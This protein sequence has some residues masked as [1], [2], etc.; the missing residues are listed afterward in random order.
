MALSLEILRRGAFE[1]VI[2]MRWNGIVNFQED[3]NASN[4]IDRVVIVTP[5]LGCGSDNGVSSLFRAILQEE[6]PNNLSYLFIRQELPH[7]ITCNDNE[8]MIRI[9]IKSHD[10]WISRNSN[11]MSNK[12]SNWST[13][14]QSW[15]VL[16]FKPNSLRS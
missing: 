3:G 5:F 9:Q 2:L 13:H 7:T 4:V 15:H 1:W 12:I 16:I 14:C 8:L 6:W 11:L 10:F